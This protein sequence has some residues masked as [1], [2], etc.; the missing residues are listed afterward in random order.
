MTQ[1]LSSPVDAGAPS[2]T[3]TRRRCWCAGVS[4]A[5]PRSRRTSADAR[6]HAA[7][8][9]RPWGT[10]T[11]S[12]IEA[13]RTAEVSGTTS[14]RELDAYLATPVSAPNR[15]V[16]RRSVPQLRAIP[17]FEQISASDTLVSKR[18]KPASIR[19]SSSKCSHLSSLLHGPNKEVT[20]CSP[21]VRVSHQE[22]FHGPVSRRLNSARGDSNGR[23]KGG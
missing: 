3:A 6:R 2:Q 15:P 5:A 11:L 23:P 19:S 22:P 14:L 9:P 4:I 12:N 8:R 20:C 10:C 13:I 7:T 18:A 21:N 17:P 1:V 16:W